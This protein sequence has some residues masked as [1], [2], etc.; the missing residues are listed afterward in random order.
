MTGLNQLATIGNGRAIDRSA[1]PELS[2]GEFHQAIL[3]A[4]EVGHRVTS[5]FGVA[6]PQDEA[7]RLY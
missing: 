6:N 1:I 4:V 7:V 5:L 2:V 3:D